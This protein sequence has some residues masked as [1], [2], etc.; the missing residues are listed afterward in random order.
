MISGTFT[1]PAGA[2]FTSSGSRL[3]LFDA[4]SGTEINIGTDEGYN[5]SSTVSFDFKGLT[6]GSYKLLFH[7]GAS[8][9]KDQRYKNGVSLQTAD[10]ISVLAGQDV[11]SI[12]WTLALGATISGTVTLPLRPDL[13]A[14]DPTGVAVS[15]YPASGTDPESGFNLTPPVRTALVLPDGTYQL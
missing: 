5:G 11:A 12:D 8:G 9:A 15:A 7:G 3:S 6:A 4:S 2:D 10:T 14:P 13:P 1:L